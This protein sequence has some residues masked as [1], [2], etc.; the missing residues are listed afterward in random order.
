[1]A[2]L[3]TA[4]FGGG[5]DRNGVPDWDN[6]PAFVGD[7]FTFARVRYN[8]ERN[9]FGRR[10]GYYGGRG[11]WRTDWPDSDLNFS[12]RLQQLTSLKVNPIP[13]QVSLTDPELYDYPFLYM[14]EPGSLYFSEEEVAGLRRY[15]DQ[16]GFMMVDDFWGESEWYNFYEQMRRVYP[17]REP[18]DVPLSHPIFHI[19][20]DL[21]ER[22][23]VPSIHNWERTGLTY[24]RY[25]AQEVHYRAYFGDDGRMTTFV[26][27][28]TDLGD[29][30]ER[31]G[32]NVD[33]F[34]QFSERWAYPMGINIVVYA[35]T[36]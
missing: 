23:Q 7:A 15:L 29:G 4:Q 16:G 12:F 24:E 10:R 17:D 8:A 18:V 3:A 26:C 35:M 25:D 30:W 2:G 1:M 21:K 14:I 33:Y 5:F 19:V 22:P 6:P 32:E 36:H 11:G 34:H 28:N 9:G 27:H 31:E 20:Y 13:A